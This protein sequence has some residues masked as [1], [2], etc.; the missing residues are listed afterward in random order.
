MKRK[1]LLSVIIFIAGMLLL[2]NPSKGEVQEPDSGG[3]AVALIIDSSGSMKDN[4]PNKVRIEAA[5]KIVSLLGED[6]QVTVV[7]FSDRAS[8][9]IPL[10]LVGNQVSR[11]EINAKLSAIGEKGDTDIKG[12]LESAFAELS[13]VDNSKKK[14]A[15]LLSD[16]E[17]D[18]PALVQDKQKMASYLA[19][20][21]KLAG[22]YKNRGW[23]V[24]C[25]ALQ[26]AAAGQTLQK[27]A[28]IT[29]GE[30]FFV[31]DAAE[32]TNF[33]QSMLLVQKYTEE[34]KPVISYIFEN[35]AY[36]VGD[37]IPV[38]ASLI[39]GK[40]I[41]IPGPHLKL[42]K[43]VLSV[44]YTGQEPILINMRDDGQNASGDQRAG[45]GIYSALADCTLKGEAALTLTALGSYRSL[46]I[47]EQV[48]I[49]RVQV[50]P[51]YSTL[52]KLVID[53]KELVSVNQEIILIAGA[54]AAGIIIVIILCIRKNKS[55][56]TK[57]R[58]SLQYSVE[59]PE[60]SSDPEV[61]NLAWPDKSEILI[62]TEKDPEADF[63]LPMQKRPF[64]MKIKKFTGKHA[65]ADDI[66]EFN[67]TGSSLYYWVICL[68]GTY[69]VSGGMPKSRQQI[70]HEDQFSVGGYIFRFISKEAKGKA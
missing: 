45:D 61:L 62:T 46:A 7:E 21:E 16:G 33:F 64:S 3:L 36:K 26:K 60:V 1:L 29:G 23:T 41:L 49:G 65:N 39:V 66:K 25:V 13:K 30:Y 67:L 18:L 57:I 63:V 9:L 59:G 68:P 17:P 38:N 56:M 32:L 47:N 58:G 70:F 28:Q 40:D 12:G 48:E 24:N 31:K 37:K 19:E 4:D 43:L 44:N 35:K 69:L 42:D 15:L 55:D 27:I 10:K 52:E 34:E 14:V 51:Q 20:V 11:N 2:L 54:A 53:T 50:K 8:V 5:K 22:E 6:D